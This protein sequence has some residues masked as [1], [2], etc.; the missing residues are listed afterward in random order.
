M[1]DIAYLGIKMVGHDI[2]VL[3]EVG[4]IGAWWKLLVGSCNKRKEK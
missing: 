2:I 4:E 3:G 1:P